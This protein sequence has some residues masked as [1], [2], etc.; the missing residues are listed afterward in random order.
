MSDTENASRLRRELRG[1][2][3]DHARAVEIFF[4]RGELVRGQVYQTHRRCGKPS[5][6]CARGEPHPFVGF[7]ASTPEGQKRRALS[8][9]A[10]ERLEPLAARYRRFRETRAALARLHKAILERIDALEEALLVEVDLDALKDKT[11]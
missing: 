9:A 3:A 4:E 8:R 7:V 5:C 10:R 6:H 11:E 1:L 2:L